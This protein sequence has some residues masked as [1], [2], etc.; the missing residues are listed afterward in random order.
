MS[1][2]HFRKANGTKKPARNVTEQAR[3]NMIMNL[4]MTITMINLN[5]PIWQLTVG[6][7]LELQERITL[8]LK[9]AETAPKESEPETRFV[10]GL[11]GLAQ[12]FNCS[13]TTANTIKQSGDI[14]KAII[15]IG[16]KIIIDAPLALELRRKKKR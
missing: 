16:R 15:Q 1:T 11:E 2:M 8:K 4:I 13:K 7:F 10:Y 5:T 14:D 9:Q 6:E 3:L 12:L